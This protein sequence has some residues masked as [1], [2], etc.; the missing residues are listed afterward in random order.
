MN[1]LIIDD[2]PLTSQG[3]AALLS[4]HDASMRVDCLNSA[5]SAR[6]R[7]TRPPAP[8]WIFLDI[9]LPDDPQCRLLDELCHSP[10]AVKTILVSAVANQQMIRRAIASGMRGFIPKSADTALVLDGF[11]AIQRGEVFMPTRL[12]AQIRELAEGNNPASSGAR[13]LSPRLQDVLQHVLR[14]SPNKVIA[15]DMGLSAHTV[16]EYISS[17]LAFHQVRNRLELVLKLRGLESDQGSSP[18]SA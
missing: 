13:A 8:D 5:R 1:L 7:L 6:E 14:G 10:L 16:K 4:S 17:I 3:L 9:Q 18:G 12:A 15:R 2:H 11:S